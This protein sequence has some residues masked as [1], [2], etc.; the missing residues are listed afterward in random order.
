MAVVD[1]YG[2]YVATPTQNTTPKAMP[3]G[4]YAHKAPN[5]HFD[6][7]EVT[8]GDSVGSKLYFGR[9]PRS[10]II[11][12]QSKVFFGALGASV[13][14]DIGD[15]NSADGLASDID[16]SAAGSGDFLEAVAAENLGKPLWELLGYASEDAA[17]E[18]LT[19]YGTLAGAAAGA[20]KSVAFSL[21][22]TS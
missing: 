2:N 7:C 6:R 3:T 13:T 1:I 22:W 20:T 14:L 5:M 12:P 15:A 17:E 21:I 19:L 18:T 11:L 9:F 4:P 10:A 16:V 8:S